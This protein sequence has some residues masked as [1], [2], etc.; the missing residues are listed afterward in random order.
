MAVSVKSLNGF[1]AIKLAD[2]DENLYGWLSLSG[3]EVKLTAQQF[4]FRHPDFPLDKQTVVTVPVKMSQLHQMQQ[5]VMPEADLA[6]IQVALEA[7]IKELQVYHPQPSKQGKPQSAMAMLPKQK[8]EPGA[9]S[10][11]AKWPIFDK[12]KMKTAEPV[13]LSDAGHLYQPVKGTSAGSRYFLVAAND[14]LRVGARWRPTHN[15]LSIRVEGDSFAKH[16]GNI[17]A[18][19]FDTK[20]GYASLHLSCPTELVARKALGAVILGLGVTI[21][22]P[23]PD[24]AVIA[25]K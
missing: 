1:T 5:G 10:T 15:S 2:I 20:H 19:G 6:E 21:E 18:A 4:E 7:A 12:A 24:L 17:Q 9:G 25:E 3:F 22:T 13:S 11:P 23:M 16:I 8:V 14:H